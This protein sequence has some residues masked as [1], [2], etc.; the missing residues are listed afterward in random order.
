MGY[1]P[2]EKHKKGYIID[3]WKLKRKKTITK[4]REII[5]YLEI[6]H[7]VSFFFGGATASGEEGLARP[8]PAQP[9]MRP[10][11]ACLA[12]PLAQAWCRGSKR[13]LCDGGGARDAVVIAG[14]PSSRGQALKKYVTICA[15]SVTYFCVAGQEVARPPAGRPPRHVDAS[16]TRVGL[17]PGNHDERVARKQKGPAKSKK[18][19][20]AASGGG[21]GMVTPPGEAPRTATGAT[22]ATAETD[23]SAQSAESPAA[24]VTK[25]RR[26][27]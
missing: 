16:C 23:R 17:A 9:P 15:Q 14:V 7:M 2:A 11:R 5:F 3:R 6:I 19:A 20:T 12:P 13:R 22:A 4:H 18:K 27:T 10:P 26:E 25:R 24:A 1:V 8:K 21:G